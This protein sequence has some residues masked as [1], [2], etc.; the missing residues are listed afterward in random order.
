MA[1]IIWHKAAGESGIPTG[2]RLL[3]IATPMGTN[4]VDLLPDIVVGHSHGNGDFVPVEVSHHT[5]AVR[6]QLNVMF[7]AELPE[8]PDLEGLRPLGIR[9]LNT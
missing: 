8:L 7:W 3:L 1:G 5:N 9:D 2:R 6:P 4:E